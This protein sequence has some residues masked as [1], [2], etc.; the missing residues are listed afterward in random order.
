MSDDL[1]I[2]FEGEPGHL[3]IVNGPKVK[4]RH[5]YM[6]AILPELAE[7]DARKVRVS[8]AQKEDG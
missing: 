4:A 3:R 1:D 5:E 2:T 8:T 6:M 7:M